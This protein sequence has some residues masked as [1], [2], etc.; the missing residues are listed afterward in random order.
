MLQVYGS[1]FDWDIK[2]LSQSGVSIVG[3]SGA[4]APLT[5]SLL[6]MFY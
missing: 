2:L 4:R 1:V 5:F 3:P 6:I